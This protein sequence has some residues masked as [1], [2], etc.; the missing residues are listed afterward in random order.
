MVDQKLEGSIQDIKEF[1]DMWVKFFDNVTSARKMEN[2]AAKEEADFLAIKSSIARRHEIIKSTLPKEDNRLDPN[3][4][5]ILSSAI[6]LD[7]VRTASDMAF[8]KIENEWHRAYISINETLGALE[9]R[10]AQIAGISQMDIFMQKLRRQWYMIVLVLIAAGLGAWYM[11]D[12]TGFMDAFR[13]IQ[14]W[15]QK[16]IG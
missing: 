15:I 12:R 13:N 8:K 14:S 3:T 9:N 1:M 5:N 16:Q 4:M 10:R 11:A 7:G 2:P 6:S